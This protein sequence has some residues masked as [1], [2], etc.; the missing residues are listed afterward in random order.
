[1]AKPKPAPRPLRRYTSLPIVLDMLLNQRLTLVSYSSWKD[2]ND[3]KSM[4][5]YQK[6]LHLGFVGAMCLTGAAETFHHWQVFAGDSS[7][8][9]V[10]FHREPFEAMIAQC[11]NCQFGAMNYVNLD[12]IGE[13][14]ATDIHSLPF[15]KRKGFIDEAELRV[16][17]HAADKVDKVDIAL[18]PLSVRQL[19]FSPFM[20][21]DLVASAKR[22]IRG[23]PG[24]EK[25]LITHSRLTDSQEWQRALAKFPERHGITYG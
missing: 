6:T 14:D 3:R 5:V 20:H 24:W 16:I 21:P 11:A 23:L 13:I 2:A 19:T 7:G 4:E 8:V 25:L 17:G 10:V 15:L 12:A 1:M 9:C 18:D 22:V